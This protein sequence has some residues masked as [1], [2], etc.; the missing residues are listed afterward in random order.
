VNQ[1][2]G[3]ARGTDGGDSRAAHRGGREAEIAVIRGIDDMTFG[4]RTKEQAQRALAALAS[5]LGAT[6]SAAVPR[7]ISGTVPTGRPSV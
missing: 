6:F 2:G 4:A 5:F 7:P 1:C 3:H